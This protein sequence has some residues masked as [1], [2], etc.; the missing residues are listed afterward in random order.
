M[1]FSQILA[2]AGVLALSAPLLSS[3]AHAQD[4]SVQGPGYKVGEGTVVHPTVGAETGFISNVFYEDTSPIAAA[5]LRLTGDL[6]FAS[7]D[8]E[9]EAVGLNENEGEPPKYDFSAG[10]RMTY[11]EY[12]SGERTVQDQ[13]NL[14]IG[15]NIALTVFP[16][17][18][19]RFSISDN[20]IRTNRPTNFESSRLLS[21]NVNHIKAGIAIQGKDSSLKTSFRVENTIDFFE[22]TGAGIANRQQS[23]LGARLD[24]QFLPIT[25]FYFDASYGLYSA[26]GNGTRVSATPLRLILGADT[27]ITERT[28]VKVYSGFVT[29]FYASGADYLTAAYGAE[30]GLRYSPVGRATLGYKHDFVD[31]INANFYSDHALELKVDQ[32]VSRALVTAKAQAILRSYQGI[33]PLIGAST[34]DDFI[35]GVGVD[36][37]YEMKEWLALSANYLTQVVAT[38]Y[39]SVVDGDR[40]DPSYAR[41]TFMVG[42]NAAF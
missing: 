17:G 40:D 5:I 35:L 28:T 36:A 6:A 12:L 31:S 21:R 20:F 18:K 27:A 1:K 41:H 14:G 32:Q 8:I 9:D 15:A 7:A 13:R 16:Q 29:G 4:V 3:T 10:L 30:F 2:S 34:R 25:R 33:S 38:D 22:S 26:I 24:W 19:V 37:G 11:E 42:A 23:L 39:V